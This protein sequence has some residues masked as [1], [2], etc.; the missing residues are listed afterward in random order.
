M[1]RKLTTDRGPQF[2]SEVMRRICESFGI[3]QAMSTAYHPQTDGQTERVNQ[4]LEEMLRIYCEKKPEE[5]SIY[6]P[7]A[8]FAYNDHLHT[9]TKKTP[10][11]ALYGYNPSIHWSHKVTKD[12]RITDLT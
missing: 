11:Q 7:M 4:S 10:F 8:E 1:P 2:T 9:S 12:D 6:L 3:E 5:W